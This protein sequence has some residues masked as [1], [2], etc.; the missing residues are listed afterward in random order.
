MAQVKLR[1]KE[2]AKALDTDKNL[3]HIKEMTSEPSLEYLRQRLDSTFIINHYLD[4]LSA[5][6]EK[7]MLYIYYIRQV[8]VNNN[9]FKNW[10]LLGLKK[11]LSKLY[12]KKVELNIVNQKYFYLNSDILSKAIA[13]RVRNRNNRILIEMNKSLTCIALAEIRNNPYNPYFK[14]KKISPLTLNKVLKWNIFSSVRYKHIQGVRIEAAGRLS[15]R[16]TAARSLSKITLKGSLKNTQK[17]TLNKDYSVLRGNAKPNVQY[18]NLNAK[19]RNGAFGLK[20]WIS[21]N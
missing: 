1:L 15:Q 7:K 19:T 21:S 12:N 16:L 18:T 4:Y 10:F 5:L 20:G 9:K 8:I 3:I 13:T 11:S 17:I 14:L 6:Y 2:M